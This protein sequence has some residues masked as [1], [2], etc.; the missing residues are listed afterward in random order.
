MEPTWL[1][2]VLLLVE[3]ETAQQSTCEQKGKR[4][5]LH[6][7]PGNMDDRA[8][9]GPYSQPCIQKLQNGKGFQRKRNCF[10][11]WIY[12]ENT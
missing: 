3:S 7:V 8:Q 12:S 10:Q 6:K 4:S 11:A 9:N 1:L 2:E 5:H